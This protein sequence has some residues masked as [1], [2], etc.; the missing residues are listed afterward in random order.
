M[1]IV[2]LIKKFNYKINS[3]FFKEGEYVERY[4]DLIAEN[5]QNIQ[6]ILHIGAGRGIFPLFNEKAK[7]SGKLIS[8]DVNEKAL[9]ENPNPIKVVANA[10]S[11]PFDDNSIDLIVTEHTFEHLIK[12][13][14]VLKECCR[15]L[16]TGG[17]LIFATP[18]RWSYISLSG[19]LIPFRWHAFLD[20]FL[21]G[22]ETS[23]IDCFPTY[24]RLNTISKIKKLAKKSGFRIGKLESYVGEPCYTTF[25]PGFHLLFVL[26]HKILEKFNFL[27]DL[28]ISIIGVLE[29]PE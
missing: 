23:D 2:G 1:R 8:L 10:E 13:E 28:R 5:C 29:K 9:R 22:H 18:N 26:Y 20:K 3:L 16:K 15:V 14:K 17:K 11:M 6:N 25:L 12:P 19:I 24:Y 21:R 7:F 27:K 4:R